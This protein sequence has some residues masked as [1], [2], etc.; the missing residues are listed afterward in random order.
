LYRFDAK[1]NYKLSKYLEEPFGKSNQFEKDFIETD[2]RVNLMESALS[3][4]Y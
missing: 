2:K 4:G 1:G 3:G